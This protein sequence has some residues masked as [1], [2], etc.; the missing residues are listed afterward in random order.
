MEMSEGMD[1]GD[2]LK[3]RTIAIDPDETSESLFV[4]FALVS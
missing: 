3:I 2:M 1:E 4:K